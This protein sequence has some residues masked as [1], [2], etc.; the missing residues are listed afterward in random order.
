MRI[1]SLLVISYVCCT[2]SSCA[3]VHTAR[4]V[5]HT[6][7]T[8][9]TTVKP[10]QKKNPME[11]SVYYNQ[12]SLKPPYKPY[13]IIGEA[14]I[15]NFNNGGIKRQDAIIHDAMRSVA[16]SMGGDAI[17][18]ITRTPTAVI[19]KVISYQSKIAV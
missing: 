8:A 9:Q 13:K 15:S 6:Q 12:I 17:I 2:L 19:G 7:N 4:P 11:V 14:K 3:S 1:S 16:A 5:N 10:P 18:D